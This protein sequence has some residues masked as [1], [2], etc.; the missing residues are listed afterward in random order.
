ML[1]WPPLPL[2]ILDR[3][4][5]QQVSLGPS[6]TSAQLAKTPWLSTHKS[7]IG[8]THA[9]GCPLGASAQALGR[10]GISCNGARPPASSCCRAR[11]HERV[12]ASGG[13]SACRCVC[14]LSLT[15]VRQGAVSWACES[16]GQDAGRCTGTGLA[17][18]GRAGGGKG[19]VVL[20]LP[21]SVFWMSL[22]PAN[23]VPPP[24]CWELTTAQ[25]AECTTGVALFL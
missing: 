5:G 22:S 12:P 23:G 3:G 15:A 24:S 8:F 20:D 6:P 18:V 10:R 7:G 21:P 9:M 1:T 2:D 16:A 17:V 11:R 14:V 4:P 19:R 13:A 25:V